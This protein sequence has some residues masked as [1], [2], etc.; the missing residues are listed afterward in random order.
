[1]RAAPLALTA[2]ALLSPALAAAQASR[3]ET[4]A[5]IRRIV[6]EAICL[7]EAYPDTAL[8]RDS[9]AVVGVYLG[10]LGARATPERLERVRA[11][12]KEARPAAPTPVGE[13]NFAIARCVLFAG[14]ADV[15]DL[16]GGGRR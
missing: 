11:L 3:R 7:A 6:A 8:A 9:A 14:R 5:E 4:P 16:L 10:T 2:L 1:M 12:A 15:L 13:R